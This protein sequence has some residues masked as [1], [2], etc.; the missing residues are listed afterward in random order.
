MHSK[1]KHNHQD[2]IFEHHANLPAYS[3]NYLLSSWTGRWHPLS[4]V[5]IVV[6]L[7]YVLYKENNFQVVLISYTLVDSTGLAILESPNMNIVGLI[8]KNSII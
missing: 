6:Y 1:G 3:P 4:L 5:P 2:I 8:F 7:A